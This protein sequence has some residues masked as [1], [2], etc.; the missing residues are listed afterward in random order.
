M[1]GIEQEVMLEAVEVRALL[2]MVLHRKCCFLFLVLMA[3]ASLLGLLLW[4]VPVQLAGT[5]L[6][7]WPDAGA[8]FIYD[9]SLLLGQNST[10]SDQL[11]TLF[12]GDVKELASY[13]QGF[14]EREHM[15][16]EA[17]NLFH[18]LEQIVQKS[19]KNHEELMKEAELEQKDFI[20]RLEEASDLFVK[21]SMYLFSLPLPDSSIS[22]H[23][24]SG[25]M[26]SQIM[27]PSSTKLSLLVELGVFYF[28]QDEG[29]WSNSISPITS[30]GQSRFRPYEVAQC[31][32]CQMLKAS[33]Y[34]LRICAGDCLLPILSPISTQYCCSSLDNTCDL[35]GGYGSCRVSDDHF[36][37]Q[38]HLWPTMEQ[39][40][41]A[42][43]IPLYYRLYR[44]IKAAEETES[45]DDD[46]DNDNDDKD[47]SETS[48]SSEKSEEADP[49][50][51]VVNYPSPPEIN[52]PSPPE[53]NNPSPPEFNNPSPPEFN[54]PSPPSF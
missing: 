28:L 15:E 45:Q 5:C 37:I 7:C 30:T 33:C 26:L 14:L 52:F 32:N 46:D 17:G 8:Y 13:G 31:R 4:A 6:R 24:K 34:D 38:F 50:S 2:V 10:A 49:A 22:V 51:P 35:A 16:R 47:S 54:I 29:G 23:S 12:L 11:E 44:H 40:K 41:T 43:T 53:F 21:E 9:A 25:F 1:L 19:Q 20:K 39:L 3:T 42:L 36:P 27:D 48:E 18:H